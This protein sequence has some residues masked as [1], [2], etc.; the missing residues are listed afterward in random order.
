[1]LSEAKHLSAS[2]DR[3]FAEFTLERSEG[4][5][6]TCVTVQT[7]KDFS[8]QLNLALCAYILIPQLAN[9]SLNAGNFSIFFVQ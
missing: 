8:S 7:V 6:A 2:R 3:P 1:M 9:C 4:L 5:R